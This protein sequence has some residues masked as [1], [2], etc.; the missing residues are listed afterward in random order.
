M[1]ENPAQLH[2]VVCNTIGQISHTIRSPGGWSLWVN[3]LAWPRLKGLTIA[4]PASAPPSK[5]GPMSLPTPT[6]GA[7]MHLVVPGGFAEPVAA[8]DDRPERCGC[9][10]FAVVGSISSFIGCS[11][12]TQ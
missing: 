7:H 11:G 4:L 1:A 9:T 6:L 8:E 5:R 2:V 12:A 3:V 10:L